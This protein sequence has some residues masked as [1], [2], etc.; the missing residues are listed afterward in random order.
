MSFTSGS[1]GS[2][3][4]SGASNP[5]LVEFREAVPAW[6]NDVSGG[7]VSGLARLWLETAPRRRD[8]RHLER[9]RRVIALLAKLDTARS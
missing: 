3:A 6:L 7:T 1:P 9:A 8:L 2:S 4:P 5:F